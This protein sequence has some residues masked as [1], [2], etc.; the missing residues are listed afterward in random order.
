M[1]PK[2][3]TKYLVRCKIQPVNT[4]ISSHSRVKKKIIRSKKTKEKKKFRK[5][6]KEKKKR[7]NKKRK[8]KKK[9]RN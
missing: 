6:R 8:R 3:Q 7:I 4:K 5:T 2:I 1:K 9:K